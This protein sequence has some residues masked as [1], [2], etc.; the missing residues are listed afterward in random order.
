MAPPNMG[1][2][3]RKKTS[4]DKG[5]AS[6]YSPASW[7]IVPTEIKLSIMSHVFKGREPFAA[8]ATVSQEWRD[9]VEPY[10]FSRITLT[11]SR[12]PDF[13]RMTRRRRSHV[14]H[15][16]LSLEL[17]P[18]ACPLCNDGDDEL[19]ED[20]EDVEFASNP[21]DSK[22]I[23]NAFEELFRVLSS[24]PPR[25]QLVLDISAYSETDRQHDFKYLSFEPDWKG[26]DPVW[27]CRGRR[28]IQVQNILFRV[29]PTLLPTLRK[30]VV[31]ENF[32]HAYALTEFCDLYREIRPEKRD[33]LAIAS[34]SLEEFSAS[35]LRD[36]QS[37]FANLEQSWRWPRLTHFAMTSKWLAE[38]V[39]SDH[40]HE[41]LISVATAAKR[42]PSLRVM[43]IWNGGVF[44]AMLFRY[45]SS[46]DRRSVTVLCRGTW[47]LQISSNVK[48][49]WH[50]VARQERRMPEVTFRQEVIDPGLI[51][52]H[53]SAISMLKLVNQVIRPISLQQI[54]LETMQRHKIL[55]GNYWQ[56]FDA[57]LGPLL[58][59]R[60]AMIAESLPAASTEPPAASTE[61]P[62]AS[63]EP[64]ADSTEAG[65]EL[66]AAGSVTATP[67]S[68]RSSKRKRRHSA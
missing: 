67:P 10:T 42:M 40:I 7:H 36:A 47:L 61:P 31:F 35:F 2:T 19:E 18:Y 24:W 46:P 23:E 66:P 41:M 65:T 44:H 29:F 68:R 54:H 22:T 56:H 21:R 11:R 27:H 49:M 8:L 30:L 55:Q 4:S 52:S 51:T 13:G 57:R 38:G 39:N 34:L 48:H 15:L 1:E 25:G 45:E 3:S 43:E 26:N 50:T 17:Q 58:A 60:R 62:A 28:L 64:P 32:S 12:L 63:T 6:N 9:L 59:A 16:W 14:R 33:P 53:A 37:F 20:L 5:S